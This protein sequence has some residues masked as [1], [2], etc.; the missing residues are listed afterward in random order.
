MP[1]EESRAAALER[2]LNDTG[3]RD[4]NAAAF[5]AGWDAA[6]AHEPIHTNGSQA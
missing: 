4:D 1:D 3:Q 2:Y 6:R 5:Q